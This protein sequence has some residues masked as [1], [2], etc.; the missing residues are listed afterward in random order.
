MN[1]LRA[2][3][4]RQLVTYVQAMIEIT[5]VTAS[6]RDHLVAANERLA[7]AL[8]GMEQEAGITVPTA[9]SVC[10]GLTDPDEDTRL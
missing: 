9:L 3:W 6:Y 1:K 7:Q 10:G 5:P 8:M 2:A 4:L